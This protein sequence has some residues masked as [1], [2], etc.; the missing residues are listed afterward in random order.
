MRRLLLLLA[1]LGAAWGSNVHRHLNLLADDSKRHNAVTSEPHRVFALSARPPPLVALSPGRA[2]ELVCE[3][4]GSPAPS[5]H[6][7]KNDAPVY[8]HDLESS[9]QIDSNPESLAR[10]VSTLLVT[11]VAGEDQYRCVVKSGGRMLSATSTVYR[12]NGSDEGG[13]EPPRPQPPRILVWYRAY[14]AQIGRRAVL[15]CGARGRP[16]PAVRWTRRGSGD[17]EEVELKDGPRI[18]ILRSGELVLSDLKWSDLGEYACTAR[19][20][21]GRARAHTFLYPAKAG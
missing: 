3:A 14:V 9:E 10:V 13:T 20:S 7:Y 18:K 17:A 11:S 4:Y 19:N 1:M 21:R 12:S 16:R 8:E 15:P 5:I 6:W 2:A